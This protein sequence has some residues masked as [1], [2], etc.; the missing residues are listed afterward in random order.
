[1]PVVRCF[2]DETYMVRESSDIELRDYHDPGMLQT[3]LVEDAT[4]FFH[5]PGRASERD[6]H[7][8]FGLKYKEWLALYFDVLG[9]D[10]SG[11]DKRAAENPEEAKNQLL[12]GFEEVISGYPM[13]SRINNILHDAV[14]EDVEVEELREECLRVKAD[15]SNQAALSGLNK[16][17]HICDWARELELN[18]FLMCD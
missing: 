8:N 3:W 2:V 16:L 14:F 15:T 13:L 11:F 7:L 12:G 1:M 18:I 4:A 17:I 9:L 10:K 5:N 6:R